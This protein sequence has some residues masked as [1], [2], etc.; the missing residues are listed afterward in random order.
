MN[1]V[2]FLIGLGG[3]VNGIATSLVNDLCLQNDNE[4]MMQLLLDNGGG[5]NGGRPSVPLIHCIERNNF[6][7]ARKL[8]EKEA[9]VSA[10]AMAVLAQKSESDEEVILEIAEMMVERGGRMV[11][12]DLAFQSAIKCGK[13]KL[14]KLLLDNGASVCF[15]LFF[16]FLFLLL[17]LTDHRSILMGYDKQYSILCQYLLFEITEPYLCM[18]KQVTKSLQMLELQSC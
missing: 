14:V 15:L 16:H 18:G 6:K 11:I 3:E 1:M 17:S 10:V 12:N 2:R 4:E 8:L 9:S 5:A 13:E 7:M